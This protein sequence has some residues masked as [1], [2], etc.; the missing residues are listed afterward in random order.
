MLDG[1]KCEITLYSTCCNA[2]RGIYYYTSYDNSTITGVDMGR[3]NLDADEVVTY[4]MNDKPALFIK[5]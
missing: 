3:E 1:G 2:E 4:P 5:N